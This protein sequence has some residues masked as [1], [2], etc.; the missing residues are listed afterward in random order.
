MPSGGPK[1]PPRGPNETPRGP[2]AAPARL[3]RGPQ[4]P[5]PRGHNTVPNRLLNSPQGALESVPKRRKASRRTD[6][7]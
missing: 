1:R 4:A 6:P 2:Q 3:P 5:P 7:Q